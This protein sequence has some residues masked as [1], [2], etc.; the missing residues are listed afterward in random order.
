LL[1]LAVP[2]PNSTEGKNMSNLAR[3]EASDATSASSFLTLLEARKTAM[4]YFLAWLV[5]RGAVFPFIRMEVKENSRTLQANASIGKGVLIMHIPRSLMI[6]EEA[7]KASQIGKLIAAKME[8]MSLTGYFSVFLLEAKRTS[9][10]WKPYIHVLPQDFST[11]PL[12]FS[13]AEQEEL[14]GT[15]ALRLIR[16]EL[17]WIRNEYKLLQKFLPPE[18]RFTHEEY[19]WAK[20]AIM[21]RLHHVVIGQKKMRALTPLADMPDHDANANVRWEGEA[22]QGFIYTAK[23]DIEKDEVLTIDYRTTNNSSSFRLYGFCPSEDG[24]NKTE[25][26]LPSMQSG[27]PFHEC[28]TNLGISRGDKRAFI[29]SASHN[30]A[31]AQSMLS[32]LRLYALPNAAGVGSNE[33]GEPVR[34]APEFISLSNEMDALSTLNRAC[35]EQLQRF[36]TSIEEDEELLQSDKLPINLSNAV[37]VRLGEKKVLKYF[38]D[39]K[40]ADMLRN[41]IDKGTGGQ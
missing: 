5:E 17:K 4:Q 38:Q 29:V 18:M 21:S 27:H 10:F 15:Y 26:Q 16:D 2:E 36:S 8:R 34:S 13:E 35:S 28:A 33:L 37:R 31:D 41:A 14:H 3:I 30:N 32:Y 11:H 12:F 25:I 6:T 39:L 22:S 1:F 23:R 20:C 19:L 9:D 40:W 7:V 24:N